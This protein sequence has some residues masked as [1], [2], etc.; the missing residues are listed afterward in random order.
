MRKTLLRY[1]LCVFFI[2]SALGFRLSDSILPVEL[3]YFVG[4][5]TGPY[6][7]LRWGTATE[8]SNYGFDVQRT[9]DFL[10]WETLGFV[11]GN[12][13]SNSPKHYSFLDST[14]TPSGIYHYRLKQIDTDGQ[15]A[16]SD[17]VTIN[18]ATSIQ[19][20]PLPPST[21]SFTNIYPN[22]L[23]PSGKI[24][25][26]LKSRS[27]LTIELFSSLG[28]KMSV[29]IGKEYEAG[30]HSLEIDLNNFTSGVYFLKITAGKDIKTLKI[31]LLK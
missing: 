19:E 1:F 8:V 20:S 4:Y 23:N 29:L 16:Y 14:V 22:P 24:N 10:E 5:V 6:V 25:F 26:S 9:P 30:D 15:F 31:I 7:D 12:G 27:L 3:I 2:V 21:F 28:Q 17:T 13:N 11:E 18:F